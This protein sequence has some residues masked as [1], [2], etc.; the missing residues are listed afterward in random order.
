MND[1]TRPA[2]DEIQQALNRLEVLTGR[3]LRGDVVLKPV[4]WCCAV[5]PA[6]NEQGIGRA[7]TFKDARALAW[8][9]LFRHCLDPREV[10]LEIPDDWKFQMM[11]FSANLNA[12]LGRSGRQTKERSRERADKCDDELGQQHQNDVGAES[13]SSHVVIWSSGV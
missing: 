10:P 5:D 12:L 2:P 3:K 7:I 13:A 11:R 6:G 1:D 4:W 8:I 9:N